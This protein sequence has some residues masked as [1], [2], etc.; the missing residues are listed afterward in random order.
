MY[1]L[2]Y[3]LHRICL[4]SRFS[5]KFSNLY[6][7]SW[8][9]CKPLKI[10]KDII[11]IVCYIVIEINFSD[12]NTLNDWRNLNVISI[13]FQLKRLEAK[14]EKVRERNVPHSLGTWNV[15]NF[16]WVSLEFLLRSALGCLLKFN[17][18]AFL[19]LAAGKGYRSCCFIMEEPIRDRLYRFFS[20][21]S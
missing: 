7:I 3:D 8:I 14:R 12:E 18:R 2:S 5:K 10:R 20:C 16:C 11:K 19:L 6:V 21:L 9:F 15:A 13:I 17:I 1:L 4:L